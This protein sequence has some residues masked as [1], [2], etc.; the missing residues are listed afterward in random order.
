M[1]AVRI[2]WSDTGYGS[3]RLVTGIYDMKDHVY[4]YNGDDFIVYL[5]CSVYLMKYAHGSIGLV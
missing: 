2:D 1:A 4:L 3:L 5:Q